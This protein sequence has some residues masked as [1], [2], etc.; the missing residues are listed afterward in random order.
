MIPTNASNEE[1][2]VNDA[3]PAIVELTEEQLSEVKRIQ[4]ERLKAEAVKQSKEELIKQARKAINTFLDELGVAKIVYIDDRCSINELKETFI[5]E[6]IALKPEKPA[7]LDYIDWDLPDAAF[8]IKLNQVW[9]ALQDA[10][11]RALFTKLL[12]FKGNQ[13]DID[14][15]IA[16]LT[17]KTHL[18]TRIELLSPKEWLAKKDAI[19][20]FLKDGHKI[21]FLFDIEFKYAPLD[22][23][24]DGTQLAA[25]LLAIEEIKDKIFCGIF[26]HKFSLEEENAKRIEFC[27]KNNFNK[28]NFYTISKKRFNEGEYLPGLA[29]GIRNTLLINEVESLKQKSKK[30][31][32]A[33]FK[34][35]LKEIDDLSPESFNH[36]IQKSSH[37]EGAWEMATL[38]RINNIITNCRA[39]DS[40]LEPKRRAAIN[41]DLAKIRKIEKVKTGGLTPTDPAQVKALRQQEIFIQ[42]DVLNKL[43]FPVSNGDIFKIKDKHYILL[44]Q[45]CNLA[46]RSNGKRV[47]DYDIGFL[48][49]LSG[50][51]E[52]RFEGLKKDM[53]LTSER[54]EQA[55]LFPGMFTIANLSKFSPVSLIPLDLTVFNQDGTAQ[56]NMN[57]AEH[58]SSAMQ[59]S[60]KL[61]YKAIHEKLSPYKQSIRVFKKLKSAQKEYLK[62]SIYQDGIFKNYDIDNEQALIHPKLKF[63]IQR[64]INYKAPYSAD[65][66][67][68]FML[69]LSRSAFDHDFL[70]V[71]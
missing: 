16:P 57:Q 51:E 14:N 20:Q 8:A 25:D 10:D 40:L 11:K 13:D 54:V 44:A 27:R 26:S 6:S 45:P 4:E 66:L 38:L 70:K 41:N 65:L 46:L 36:I 61:R 31:I 9:E 37:Y 71:N 17:L 69:Y 60:W 39:L 62:L 15:S 30:V 18:T 32:S 24:R 43:H 21:L 50:M 3:Q 42:G 64:I 67:Q 23:G 28:N 12:Y 33:A 22:D 7:E 68:K 56:I 59:L 1:S 34:N 5:G 48:I 58:P 47:R 55:E 53:A 63:D 52:E 35:A 19:L 49:E 29:E 2:K